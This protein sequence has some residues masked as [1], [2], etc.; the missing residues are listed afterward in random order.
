MKQLF[1]P[2]R[3]LSAITLLALATGCAT[4]STSRTDL[5]SAAGFQVLTA[6]TPQKQEMLKSLPTNQLSLVTWQGENFYVQPDVPNNRAYVG[7]ARE[8]QAYQQLRLARQ[9]SNDNLMAARMNQNAMHNWNRCWGTSMHN[10]F[11]RRTHSRRVHRRVDAGLPP[12]SLAEMGGFMEIAPPGTPSRF[13]SH[14]DA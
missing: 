4:T 12:R 3:L 8:F 9:L 2:F 14:H 1:N 10:C 7:R 5:L 13:R 11:H 6:D